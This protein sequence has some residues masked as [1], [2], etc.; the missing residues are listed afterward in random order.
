M[1][2]SFFYSAVF[3]LFL[4][5]SAHA[6]YAQ[7]PRDAAIL[8][9]V[10]IMNF[11]D[12]WNRNNTGGNNYSASSGKIVPDAFFKDIPSFSVDDYSVLCSITT[13]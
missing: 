6:V 2:R 10:R 5:A 7:T 8:D 9:Q 11:V 3:I 12:E 4:C 1:T 13:V